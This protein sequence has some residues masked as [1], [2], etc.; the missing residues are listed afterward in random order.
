[1]S[2]DQMSRDKLLPLLLRR[3]NVA[4]T[5]MSRDKMSCDKMLLFKK[6]RGKI[7]AILP[8]LT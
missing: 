2:P 3:P 5:K 4:M 1:M 7:R 6:S 8:N